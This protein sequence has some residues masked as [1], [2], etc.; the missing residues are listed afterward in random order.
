MLYQARKKLTVFI[1]AMLIISI[2]FVFSG[3]DNTAYAASSAGVIKSVTNVASGIKVSWSK[4]SS[5]TG[6]YIYRKVGSGSWK[7]VKTIDK[8]TTTAWTD[9]NVKNGSKYSYRVKTYKGKTIAKTTKSLFTFRLTR[10]KITSLT[11]P[12]PKKLTIKS[13]SNSKASGF[14]IRYSRNSDL[15]DSSS[16]LVKST[17]VNKTLGS[18]ANRMYYVK[19][20]AYKTYKDKKYYS[21]WSVVKSKNVY[22]NAYTL[23]EWTTLY[24]GMSADNNYIKV[25]YR[26]KLQDRGP[27]KETKT[28]TWQEVYYSYNHNG[29]TYGDVYYFLKT[30]DDP[31]TTYTA[32]KT[33]YSSSNVLRNAVINK[34]LDIYGNWNTKY[35]H[36]GSDTHETPDDKRIYAFDSSGFTS[37]VLEQGLTPYCAAYEIPTDMVKQ[38]NIDVILNEGFD[39]EIKA[40]IT[41]EKLDYDK[42][43]PGDL[44]FFN[45]DDDEDADDVGIYLGNKEFIHSTQ[46]YMRNPMDYLEDGKEA[47]GGVCIS[48]LKENENSFMFAKRFF[49]DN[50]ENAKINKTLITKEENVKVYSNSECEGTGIATLSMDE[51]V[52]L[53]Y[54]I[55][56]VNEN[57]DPVTNAYIKFG[58]NQY[59]YVSDYLDDKFTEGSDIGGEEGGEES[60]VTVE[61]LDI[62]ENG[63]YTAPEGTAYSP[64]VVNVPNSYTQSD[65]GRVVENG[66][67]VEQTSLDITSNGTVDTT[68][69]NQVVV[70]VPSG[71]E[72]VTWNQCPTAVK[73]YLANVDYTG[74]D[75]TESSVGDYAPQTAVT[76]NT[77][78]IGKTVDGVT[79]YNE[80][81]NKQTPF[82]SDNTAGTL[83]P[84]DQVR[85][86]KS[87]TSN[88][89]DVGGWDCDGGTVKYGLLYRS[90][91]L[92]ASDEDLVINQLGIKAEIDLTA[93]ATSAYGN[94][95]RFYCAPSYAMYTLN[96][97]VAWKTNLKALFDNVNYG[98]PVVFHCSMGAD[99]TGTFALI[100]EG[101]LGVSQSDMDKDYELTSFYAERARNKNYQGG[102]SD[103]AHLVA[104]VNALEGSN[105]R[106]KCV[107]FVLS[108]GFTIDDI[109]AYRQAMIEGTP[110]VLSSAVTEYTVS[111]T[112][113]NCTLDNQASTIGQYQPYD[114]VLTP[115]GANKLETVTI[116][117]DGVNITS[118]VYTEEVY[119]ENRGI[120]HIDSV[121]GNIVITATAGGAEKPLELFDP[122][123]STLNVRFDSYGNTVTANGNFVT[124]FIPVS[125]DNSGPWT[126]RIK[127]EGV[128]SKF[129]ASG[130]YESIAFFKADKTIM[131]VNYGRLAI[132]V[133]SSATNA[134]CKHNDKEGIYININQT[135]DGNYIPSSFFDLSQVAYIRV[136][137]HYNS[138]ISSTSDL[139]NV[140]IKADKI[141]E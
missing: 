70:N 134:L 94:K 27:A 131:N 82:A 39:Q 15:S 78:P 76:S 25:W 77:K 30:S 108:L 95:L 1:V 98:D 130:S 14:Q 63:S 81:P 122:S 54:T 71:K 11:T 116:T 38:G 88:F 3:Y 119:P 55:N 23:K 105:F 62:T 19:V 107:N 6:Y 29:K 117:M 60:S 52:I 74:V 65:E 24:K 97:K 57:G 91:N 109:N 93:D 124:D 75:Y 61:P 128:S 115:D 43:Y 141:V 87:A 28:G 133:N 136:C 138:S 140:S 32:P 58:D 5:K 102:T 40:V 7:K 99:R 86:I 47:V 34:A 110:E 112:L 46:S 33:N 90:G 37:Y 64:V 26:T 123:S 45:T 8:N 49:P 50:F 31:K 101:L 56:K 51:E 13:S 125:L 120:I 121:T 103:W 96:D 139:A 132:G 17:Q 21:A 118:K 80:I 83:M 48:S 137:M 92:A 12:G 22:K 2:T 127:E 9:K 89:R 73:D 66:Q 129:Q 106:D 135:G 85:W 36:T 104:Q 72:D 79:Y 100:C 111:Q 126:L 59:G 4:D 20:R 68:K 10:P 113:T 42:L 44:L 16:I 67:L 69:I 18:L 41:T 53:L 84:L 114:A 35:D